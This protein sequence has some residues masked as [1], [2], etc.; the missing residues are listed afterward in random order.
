MNISYLV[1]SSSYSFTPSHTSYAVYD[2]K[3][4]SIPVYDYSKFYS[5]CNLGQSRGSFE[6]LH[7]LGKLQ[8]YLKLNV[9]IL[10]TIIEMHVGLMK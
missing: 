6:F 3:G 10:L 7:Q 1:D 9:D 5:V 4:K 2:E 8:S